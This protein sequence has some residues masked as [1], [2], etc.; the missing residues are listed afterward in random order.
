MH[1]G[2]SL[3]FALRRAIDNGEFD[4]HYQPQVDLFDGH[5]VGVEALIRWNH[6]ELGRVPPDHFIPLAEE[7]GLMIP[8]GDWILETACRQRRVWL[9]QGL[10]PFIVAVNMSA[11]QFDRDGLTTH[12]VDA[13]EN[14]GLKPDT[15][16]VELTESSVMRD[17]EMTRAAL[18]ELSSAG[19][20]IA[21][22]D[23]GTGYSSLAY[24]KRFPLHVLKI[25][26][27]FVNDI[28]TD[29]NGAAIVR[30]IISL[31]DNLGLRSIAEGVETRDQ[32]EFLRANGCDIVQ[33][34]LLA[35]P[36]PPE[37]LPDM[38][39]KLSRNALSQRVNLI[40]TVR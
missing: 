3:A 38:V 36:T 5:V 27:S 14:A 39:R 26:G 34:F 17:P 32:L 40:A 15:I 13:I 8:M 1:V 31:A 37:D 6:P 25:D 20:L 19:I 9:D 29:P 23:F 22:D 28:T 21:I 35:R 10:P 33:G 2:I 18:E 30:T 7:L 4:L 11:Q 16:E 12:V 24:L